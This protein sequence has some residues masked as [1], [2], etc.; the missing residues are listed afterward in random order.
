MTQLIPAAEE[1]LCKMINE[2]AVK[3]INDLLSDMMKTSTLK[4]PSVDALGK[5]VRA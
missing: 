1:Q 4:P 3:Q 2:Y 5:D